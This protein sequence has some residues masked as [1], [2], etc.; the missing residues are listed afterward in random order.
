M[1]STVFPRHGLYLISRDDP[2]TGPG[3]ERELVDG[4]RGGAVVVQY[5]VKHAHDPV[6][7]AT[8]IRAR[9]RVAGIPF[10]IND[11][12]DLARAVGADGVHLGGEDV[13]LMY[14]RDRLG[15]KAIIGISC[16]DSPQRAGEAEQG[17]ADY[18]AFGRFF[19]SA[20]KP[21]AP[22]APIEALREARKRC[23]VPIVAIGGITPEN[24]RLLLDAG[25]NLLA[26]IEGVL[27]GQGGPESTA[28]RFRGLWP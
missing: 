21:L 12:V 18:V 16:Y 3:W 20:T 5:R 13:D 7:S 2:D 17:G 1:N 23:S 22:C 26:A 25:A 11:D 4:I 27:A 6:G 24:G 10:I 15:A 28:R 8:R 14:A 19:P 9:C